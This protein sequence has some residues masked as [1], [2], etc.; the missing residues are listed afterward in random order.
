MSP[1]SA[2][3]LPDRDLPADARP[4]P[5]LLAVPNVSEGRDAATIAAIAHAFDGSTLLDTHSDPDHN[6]TVFTLAGEPGALAHAAA[7][8]GRARRSR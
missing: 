1:H 4:L 7:G 6:R 2:P 8:R 5:I 3:P